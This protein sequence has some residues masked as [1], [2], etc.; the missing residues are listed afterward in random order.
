MSPDENEASAAWERLRAAITDRFDNPG[1]DADAR[2]AQ[3][4]DELVE[5]MGEKP[6]A[7]N[8]LEFTPRRR[9]AA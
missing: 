7:S 5:A 3:L 4:R 2:V 8:V 1:P 6:I 9:R